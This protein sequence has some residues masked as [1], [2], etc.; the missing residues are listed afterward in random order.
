MKFGNGDGSITKVNE[1]RRK[2]YR[3]RVTVGFLLNEKTTKKVAIRKNV[4]YYSNQEE[5][6]RAL[7]DYQK[8]GTCLEYMTFKDTF[9]KWKNGYFP[10]IGKSSQYNYEH[11]FKLCEPLHE[12][13]I[14]DINIKQMQM[15]IDNC[16][17]G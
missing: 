13:F 10:S 3:M 2:P 16:E 8:K 12:L 1:K 11:A 6:L 7:L 17:Q 14:A 9:E 5:A 4:G 15:I